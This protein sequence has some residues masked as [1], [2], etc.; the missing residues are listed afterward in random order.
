[1]T[2][3]TG[4]TSGGHSTQ[5]GGDM[6]R[7]I[8]ACLECH[9]ICVSSVPHCLKKG[10]KH[11]EPNHVRLLADCAQICITSADFMLRGSPLHAHTCAACAA[12]CAECAAECDKMGE[13]PMMQRCAESCR[14][15]AESCKRM[16]MGAH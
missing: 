3:A 9:A 2:Q 7:C 1:M 14:R 15:C 10:G 12:V 13:D 5:H 16:G 6:E 11:A 8:Q 4:Q